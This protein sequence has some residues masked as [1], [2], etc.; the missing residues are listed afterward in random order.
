ME[1]S[2]FPSS[3]SVTLSKFASFFQGE[4]GVNS[5]DGITQ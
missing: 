2:V 5:S 1:W 3:Y 4:T